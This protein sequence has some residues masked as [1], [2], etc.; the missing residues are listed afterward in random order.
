MS[1]S[2]KRSQ[3]GFFAID[4]ERW[5]ELCLEDQLNA[6][7]VYLVLCRGTGGDNTTT[8]WSVNAVESYTG[9]SRSRAKSAIQF[10]IRE[11]YIEQTKQGTKPRYKVREKKQKRLQAENTVWLP[12]S[13]VTG[14]S[15]NETPPLERI[16]QISCVMTLKLF[17][18]LYADQN[19]IENGGISKGTYRQVYQRTEVCE[20]AQYRLYL[21]SKEHC[22]L[23]W[24]Q[25][26]KPHHRHEDDLTEQEI[27]V[28]KNPGVDFFERF[29]TLE[30]LRLVQCVPYLF[31]SDS[32][33][34][35]IIHS[36]GDH[37]QLETDIRRAAEAAALQMYNRVH[38]G[39]DNNIS[40][41]QGTVLIPVP[42]H[43]R[44]VHVIG[45]WRLRYRPQT[46]MTSAWW[47][48]YNEKGKRYLLQY[49]KMLE[50]LGFLEQDREL[51]T[52]R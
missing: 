28:G 46:G 36:L 49:Q 43:R 30:T 26:T 15:A 31:E 3:D 40:L 27:E 37:E 52:S 34:A 12:N 47:K 41:P 17:V 33:D 29:K 7:V 11:L 5:T 44:N 18:D 20:Y 38:N 16:R 6:A 9:I 4:R 42:K 48:D 22:T 24:N 32:D 1:N 14:T 35:E 2:S 13:I 23:N 10:L 45:V 21:F 8:S 19:L 39:Y 51:A 25:I 50:E